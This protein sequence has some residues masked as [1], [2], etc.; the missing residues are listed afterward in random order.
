MLVSPTILIGLGGR[1][2]G[3]AAELKLI[4]A[5]ADAQLGA[6][7]GI[8]AGAKRPEPDLDT[9]ERCC[10][11]SLRDLDG[12]L[13]LGFCRRCDA[14]PRRQRVVSGLTGVRYE[15]H[16]V[17]GELL[18]QSSHVER[19]PVQRLG[20]RPWRVAERPRCHHRSA[21]VDDLDTS[22]QGATRR[23]FC[24][25]LD[26]ELFARDHRHRHVPDREAD[27]IW[28]IVLHDYEFRCAAWRPAMRPNTRQRPSPC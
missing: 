7:G 13:V 12:E 4:V 17:F 21:G 20:F 25:D 27:R 24:A 28:S 8:G 10:R 11:V 9:A 2:M 5:L 6:P 1:D 14:E 15:A 23:G 16:G 19:G 26:R 3:G 22:S 18:G